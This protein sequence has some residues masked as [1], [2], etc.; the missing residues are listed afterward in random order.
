M[1][2]SESRDLELDISH[3]Q[4]FAILRLLLSPIKENGFN[5]AGRAV[6]P[7]REV[8]VSLGDER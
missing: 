8:H 7:W 6:L 1:K 2:N 5:L 4:H 3:R